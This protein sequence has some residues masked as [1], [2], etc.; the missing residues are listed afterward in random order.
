MPIRFSHIKTYTKSDTGVEI[1]IIDRER[2]RLSLPN[3]Y[4]EFSSDASITIAISS[5]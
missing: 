2:A 4:E 1:R 3:L 5:H